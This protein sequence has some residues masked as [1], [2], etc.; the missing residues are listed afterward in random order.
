[1]KKRKISK[2][3]KFMLAVSIAAIILIGIFLAVSVLAAF[4]QD[5]KAFAVYL[6]VAVVLAALII[7][8]HYHGIHYE[9]EKCG[10]KFKAN[11]YKV[12]FTNGILG[13][14]DFDGSNSQYAKLK[15]PQCK[16]KSWCKKHSG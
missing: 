9:C 12:F 11:P 14:L 6:S 7:P 4:S 1:M 15:C 5:W 2:K 3:E 8:L 16:K 13:V 10:H